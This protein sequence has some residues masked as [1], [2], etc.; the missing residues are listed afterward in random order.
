[1]KPKLT[2]SEKSKRLREHA[3]QMIGKEVN[4][5][6][7]DI[8]S[9]TPEA[10]ASLVHNLQVHQIELQLQNEE[11]HNIQ[12]DL[13]ESQAKYYDLYNNAPVGYLAIDEAGIIVETNDTFCK[14]ISYSRQQVLNQA[15]TDFIAPSDQDLYYLHNKRLQT[16]RDHQICE[17]RMIRN[18]GKP[19]WAR[20]SAVTH[21]GYDKKSLLCLV[22]V[23][24]VT[25]SKDQEILITKQAGLLQA[26]IDSPE[27]AI[28]SL[29]MDYRYTAFNHKHQ[30]E[31]M[32][33]WKA[34]IKIGDRILDFMTIPELATQAQH[35]MD[36]A[37]RGES[38]YEEAYQSDQCIYYELHWSPVFS[39][40]SDVVGLTCFVH[41]I[42]QR[43]QVEA[44]IKDSNAYLE[45]RVQERTHQLES[46]NLELEAFASAAAHDLRG[47][48]RSITGFSQVLLED[49]GSVLDDNALK[50]LATI[51]RNADLMDSHVVSLVHLA[52]VSGTDPN[53]SR[54]DMN[55]LLKTVHK[56]I[57]S[58][59][60]T[61]PYDLVIAPLP[62]AYADPDLIYIVWSNLLSNAVKFMQKQSIRTITI[63]GV[64]RSDFV[65]YCIR[66]TGAG[67][68]PKSA[69]K[70][71]GAFQRLH[72]ATEY[73]GI[74]IGLSM[75]KRIISKHGGKVWAESEVGKGASF[76]FTIPIEKY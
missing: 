40:D 63:T 44:I 23:S 25:L 66:D 24:N 67:F 17:L 52:R 35:S 48:L 12:A 76:Y 2:D 33:V 16:S 73:P 65:E 3:E 37:L 47:P 39:K 59:Q 57:Q 38:F 49:Y 7:V 56:N 4:P 22:T 21:Y 9:M 61:P 62:P 43:K 54:I 8:H 18:S 58:E 70:L 32:K 51:K 15:I 26:L 69:G 36:R 50:L 75:V 6:S 28:F 42:T 55:R 5:E 20:M 71:F 68:D 30:T 29:D 1:M 64:K 34:E 72:S 41:N 14:L 46:A 45:Q 74:G 53:I 27:A 11:L 31:M 60:E 10:I 13:E 19:F